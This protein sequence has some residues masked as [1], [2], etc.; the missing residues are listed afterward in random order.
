[1]GGLRWR[2]NRRHGDCGL[3]GGQANRFYNCS[4]YLT[5]IFERGSPLRPQPPLLSLFRFLEGN[6]QLWGVACGR[7]YSYSS[8]T[9]ISGL[10]SHGCS[11]R[12]NL[13]LST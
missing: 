5:N 10:H 2:L 6:P 1:M 7:S 3:C 9:M 4:V 8:Y 13:E 12:S 11:T